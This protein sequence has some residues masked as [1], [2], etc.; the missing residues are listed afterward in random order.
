VNSPP[1]TA[2]AG[3]PRR[4]L[5]P[6]GPGHYG[7][8][9]LNDASG[10]SNV[11]API[12]QF[13]LNLTNRI[14]TPLQERSGLTMPMMLRQVATATIVA[15]FL[16]IVATALM[17]GP[18]YIAITL[19]FGGITIASFWKL[20]QRYSRDAEK[21]WSSDLA[22][23]YMVRAIGATEG[24]R[25]MREIGMFFSVLAT[26]MCLWVIQVRPFDLVDLTM[27]ALIFSTMAHMYLCCAEP[28]P[29]GSRRREVKLAMQPSQ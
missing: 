22:R 23:D 3:L 14:A 16:A 27:L 6:A 21:D 9:S 25:R 12:D 19:V 17:R 15:T 10:V 18:V 26:L 20:L 24:Q 5:E 28:R 8:G 29:P 13:L 4:T 1:L 7:K 11:L 2:F